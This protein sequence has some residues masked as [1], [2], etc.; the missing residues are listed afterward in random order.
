MPVSDQPKAGVLPRN[1]QFLGAGFPS[2][3]RVANFYAA[4]VVRVYER[5]Y[6]D[7]HFDFCHKKH[8]RVEDGALR[9]SF[10]T[11]FVLK[12]EFWNLK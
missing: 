4:Q 6:L 3:V 5:D 2:M 7:A 10:E 11:T 1:L 8:L 12:G 9:L